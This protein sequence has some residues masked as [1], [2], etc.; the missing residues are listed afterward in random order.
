MDGELFVEVVFMMVILKIPVVYLCL[1]VYWAIKAEPPPLEG[2]ARPARLPEPEPCP[3]NRRR[4][5]R[6]R[7]NPLRTRCRATPG[8][9]RVAA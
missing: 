4:P 2:A 3:W 1:V 6:P 8:R 7:P 9:A 5:I